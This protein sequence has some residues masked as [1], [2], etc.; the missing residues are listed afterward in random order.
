MDD[1]RVLAD[2]PK[3]LPGSPMPAILCDEHQLHL[4]FLL[5]DTSDDDDPTDACAIVTFRSCRRH[6]L[7]GLS[8]ET[9]GLHPLAKNG[10][11]IYAAMEVVNSSWISA[12][13]TEQDALYPNKP[14]QIENLRHFILTFH[15]S[16]FECLAM[17]YAVM[18]MRANNPAQA[19]WSVS[20]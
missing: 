18:V 14:M 12:L 11:K 13:K 6:T 15:D 17:D 1:L 8:D 4:A 5:S 9:F 10:L 3:M 2:I 19:L 7:G 16:C 20:L